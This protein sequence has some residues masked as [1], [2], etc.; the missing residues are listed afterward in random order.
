[1]SDAF[2][3]FTFTVE[4]IG[5]ICANIISETSTDIKFLEA[6]DYVSG[7]PQPSMRCALLTPL[8]YVLGRAHQRLFV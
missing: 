6:S 2:G 7:C 8:R 3:V 5:K 4:C 1:M